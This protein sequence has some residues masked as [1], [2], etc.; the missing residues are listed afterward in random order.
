MNPSKL[1]PDKLSHGDEIRVIAPSRSL[2]IISEENIRR[3]KLNL[4]S[5]GYLVSFSENC[6]EIDVFNSSSIQSRVEDLHNAFLDPN[7]KAILTSIGGYNCNQILP[8]VDFE[9]IKENPKIICGYS[10]ITA[11]SNAIYAKTGLVT[12]SGI[13]FSTWGMEQ[14]SS[15]NREKFTACLSSGE[16]YKVDYLDYWTDDLWFMDQDN[17]SVYRNSGP[18]VINQG[19]SQ[20][21]IL[22]GNLCTL[23]LLQ[24]TEFIPDLTGSIIFIEDD[25]MSGKAGDFYAQVFDRDLES[26][27]Q[28][29]GFEK[30]RGIVIGRFQHNTNISK[31]VLTSIVKNKS[32]LSDIP[33]VADYDFGHTNP[34]LTFPIGGECILQANNE[35]PTLIINKH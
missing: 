23:N 3:A 25:N 33:V 20:G 21:T 15:Y 5:E 2:S 9:L 27:T 22:G 4:E 14:Y 35:K 29:R 7:V 24:G 6:R 26:L 13:H 12:Y 11:L 8:Y 1:Y 19:Q 17:R 18:Y 32:A 31:A 30:V 10:D 28:H 16:E 34:I